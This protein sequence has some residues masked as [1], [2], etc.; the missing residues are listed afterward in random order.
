LKKSELTGK[1]QW[2]SLQ[3]LYQFKIMR[4]LDNSM[5]IYANLLYEIKKAVQRFRCWYSVANR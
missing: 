3:P 2:Y 5:T 4:K 1:F